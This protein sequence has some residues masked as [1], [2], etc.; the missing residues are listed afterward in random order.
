M[1]LWEAAEAFAEMGQFDGSGSAEG[2]T[3]KSQACPMTP[4]PRGLRRSE[5]LVARPQQPSARSASS[6]TP[7]PTGT[8]A[9]S[10]RRRGTK[11]IG[12]SSAGTPIQGQPRP[13]AHRGRPRRRSPPYQDAESTTRNL[14]APRVRLSAALR[15]DQNAQH[16]LEV[17]RL[18]AQLSGPGRTE[19]PRLCLFGSVGRAPP[20][21][22]RGGGRCRQREENVATFVP[23]MGTNVMIRLS[24]V[25]TMRLRENTAAVSSSPPSGHCCCRMADSA[26]PQHDPS[27]ASTEKASRA[28]PPQQLPHPGHQVV[29]V[30]RGRRPPPD[31]RHSFGS[32]TAGL[33]T[34]DIGADVVDDFIYTGV[35]WCRHPAR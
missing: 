28:P 9:A 1:P 34:K 8:S 12:S 23:G 13:G 25:D 33:A 27:V 29:A 24:Y 21:P 35:P 2:A 11:R 10:T 20:R 18:D 14:V 4:T 7:P 30:G 32:T 15:L 6:A 17:R 5:R 26:T 3:Q 22:A 31:G 19:L 16:D